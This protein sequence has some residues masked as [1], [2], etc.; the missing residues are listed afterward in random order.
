MSDDQIP[1]TPATAGA[2]PVPVAQD[3]Q[4][5][6]STL[7]AAAP[8]D[9]PDAGHLEEPPIR[10]LHERV[11]VS[12]ESEKGE[13]RSE[14]GILIPSPVQM[15]HRLAWA[16]VMAVGPSVRAVKVGDRVLFD[17]AERSE[18]EVRNK[19]Y[20]LLRERDLHAVADEQLSDAETGLY[21]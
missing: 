5:T 18:V 3:A 11:L 1:V 7:Q 10:M 12:M 21:L 8:A 15:A 13:H 9:V 19:V 4:D 17:P 14:G 20:V 6:S 2:N 16:R